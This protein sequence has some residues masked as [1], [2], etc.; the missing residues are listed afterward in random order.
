MFHL[1]TIGAATT[2]GLMAACGGGGDSPQTVFTY[3]DFNS[4]VPGTSTVAAVGLSQSDP[5]GLPD[6]TA[7]DIGTLD[8]EPRTLSINGVIVDGVYQQADGSWTANGTTV[9]PS[10]MDIFSNTSTYDFFVPVIVTASGGFASNYIVGVVSRTEDFPTTAG[11]V[12]YNGV[13]RVEGIVGGDGSTAGTSFG[14]DGTLVL[15]ADFSNNLVDAVISGL[16][17]ANVDFDTVRINDLAISTG[18]NATFASTGA[19]A[20]VFEDGGD[21]VTPLGADPTQSASGAF[22]GGN[23]SGPDGPVEAGGVFVVNGDNGNTI[24]GI[25]AAD[26]RQ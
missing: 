25:F 22:F 17:G 19:S 10:T 21:T 2:I 26:G 4:D 24:F 11:E 14:S 18:A 1:K 13:A 6:G 12:T 5:S 3:Q 7:V 15:T 20:I 16:S 23:P 9:S 8:R